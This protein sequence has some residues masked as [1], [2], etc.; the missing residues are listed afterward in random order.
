MQPDSGIN[1]AGEDWSSAETE[2]SKVTLLGLICRTS[3]YMRW[4]PAQLLQ[5]TPTPR[6]D[7][8]PSVYGRALGPR[9]LFPR[10]QRRSVCTCV[11]TYEYA[12]VRACVRVCPFFFFVFCFLK[13]FGFGA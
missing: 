13:K 7:I 6:H 1:W 8:V 11:H 2:C 12:C 9:V 3:S 10:D 5:P 4:S